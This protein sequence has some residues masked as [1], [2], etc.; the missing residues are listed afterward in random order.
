MLVDITFSRDQRSI[1]SIASPQ[2]VGPSVLMSGFLLREK[3]TTLSIVASIPGTTIS[4]FTVFA[5][6]PNI[7]SL[8]GTSPA[9]DEVAT[10]GLQPNSRRDVYIGGIGRAWYLVSGAADGSDPG[11]LAPLDYNAVTNDVHWTTG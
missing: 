8:T 7:V 5:Y 6:L 9:L 2:V 4:A 11:Q 10:V 3:R 1:A